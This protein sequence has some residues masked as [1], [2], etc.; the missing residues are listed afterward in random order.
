MGA[1]SKE[2]D[3]GCG[4]FGLRCAF[5]FIWEQPMRFTT[6]A[7]SCLVGAGDY[8]LAAAL[9]EVAFPPAT[10]AAAAAGCAQGVTLNEVLYYQ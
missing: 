3:G 6:D 8:I 9:L 2:G 4:G 7:L 5:R 10:A 1:E